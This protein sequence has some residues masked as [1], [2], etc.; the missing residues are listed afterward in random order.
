[1]PLSYLA[2]LIMNLENGNTP[3]VSEALKLYVFSHD[4]TCLHSGSDW[5]TSF[6]PRLHAKIKKK[7]FFAA[8]YHGMPATVY[9]FT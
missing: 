1:M 5:D 7:T 6:G 8:S 2:S 4:C 9:Y 3:S